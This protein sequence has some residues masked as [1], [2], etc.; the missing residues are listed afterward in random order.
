MLLYYSRDIPSWKQRIAGKSLPMEKF[1]IRKA[2]RYLEQGE[3]LVL[4]VV[5][6]IYAWN[7][8]TVLEK[9]FKLV[10]KLFVLT[11]RIGKDLERDKGGGNWREI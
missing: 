8:F 5:E 11:E 10:E 4:P 2:E 3:S 6:L 7:G 9:Q 1:C